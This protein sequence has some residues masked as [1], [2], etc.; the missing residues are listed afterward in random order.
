MYDPNGWSLPG[1]PVDHNAWRYD[2]QKGITAPG[3]PSDE[4]GTQFH[5]G[6]DF[7][8]TNG[9]H[10]L[11]SPAGQ[12][13]PEHLINYTPATKEVHAPGVPAP[14]WEENISLLPNHQG[15]MGGVVGT[16]QAADEDDPDAADI[17][18]DT[19]DYYSPYGT[20]TAPDY[21]AAGPS[22]TTPAGGGGQCPPGTTY[23][24]IT[25]TCVPNG[26]LPP[27]TTGPVR[28]RPVLD[29]NG[30]PIPGLVAGPSGQVIH[31]PNAP[32]DPNNPATWPIRVINGVPHRINPATGDAS[33]VTIGGVPATRTTGGGVRG[34]G[35]GGGAA[36]RPYGTQLHEGRDGSIWVFDP[37]SGD[38]T[39][40]MGPD[41]ARGTRVVG[42]RVIRPTEDG[43]G[44]E[45]VYEVP[46]KPQVV[47]T[48]T[49]V[50]TVNPMTGETRSVW[51]KPE[52]I[53]T[54]AH[55]VIVPYGQQA[56][57][58]DFDG[59]TRTIGTYIPRQS[60]GQQMGGSAP[61]PAE[62]APSVGQQMGGSA[63]GPAEPAP[64]LI[65]QHPAEIPPPDDWPPKEPPLGGPEPYGP[66]REEP[67]GLGEDRFVS[68]DAYYRQVG[69]GQADQMG[70]DEGVEG[71]QSYLNPDGGSGMRYP[72]Y[73]QV[74]V[75]QG[76][77]VAPVPP[78]QIVGG[79]NKFGDQVSMEGTHKGTDLQAYRGTPAV[80]PVNGVVI[81][82]QNDPQGL[83]VQVFVQSADD[84]RIHQLSHLDSVAVGPGTPVQAGQPV[85]TVGD[86]GAGATGPHLDYRIRTPDGGYQNP[87]PEL[88]PL[89]QLPEAPNTVGRG[90]APERDRWYDDPQDTVPYEFTMVR[91]IVQS[92]ESGTVLPEEREKALHPSQ[93]TYV[94]AMEGDPEFAYGGPAPLGG[95]TAPHV[96]SI[97]AL[98]GQFVRPAADRDTELRQ[99][100]QDSW[101]QPAGA[102]IRDTYPVMER[103]ESAPGGYSSPQPNWAADPTGYG[104]TMMWGNEFAR[105][106]V[107]QHNMSLKDRW[108]EDPEGP[109]Y[110]YQH[111]PFKG[112]EPYGQHLRGAYLPYENEEVAQ[113][114]LEEM[115]EVTTH[116]PRG[117]YSAPEYRHPGPSGVPSDVS[118]P[119]DDT[120]RIRPGSIPEG[121]GL[122]GVMDTD[123]VTAQNRAYKPTPNTLM[124]G[125]ELARNHMNQ[126]NMS[127]LPA[128]ESNLL[129]YTPRMRGEEWT[130]N[131]ERLP[132]G[133]HL[134]PEAGWATPVG[135]MELP[136][137]DVERFMPPY[138][139]IVRPTLDLR[140]TM[141]HG[142]FGGQLDPEEMNSTARPMGGAWQTGV[143]LQG[144]TDQSPPPQ[145]VTP[146]GG[147]WGVEF[148]QQLRGAWQ[149]WI[150]AVERTGEGVMQRAAGLAG[151]AGLLPQILFQDPYNLQGTVGTGQDDLLY[152]SG[153]SWVPAEPQYDATQSVDTG[154]SSSGGPKNI[155]IT[156]YDTE[157]L[158][159]YARGLDLQQQQIEAQIEGEQLRHEAAMAAVK[160]QAQAN[161]E[162]ARHNKVMEDLQ[163]EKLQ[164]ERDQM[165]IEL[166]EKG[167]FGQRSQF[168]LLQSAL[169]N[170]W[171]QKL[172]GMAP[173]YYDP[174]GP[175]FVGGGR[176]Q[177][178]LS[179]WV[180]GPARNFGID[181]RTGQ[182][183]SLPD[184]M[185]GNGAAQGGSPR[186]GGG[187]TSGGTTG[188]STAVRP[189]LIRLRTQL[190]QQLAN[191]QGPDERAEIQ[192]SIE[193]LKRRHPE[194]FQDSAPV[195]SGGGGGGGSIG[196]QMASN[197]GW[198]GY[199]PLGSAPP[200][201]SY[202]DWKQMD[203]FSRASWRTMSDMAQPFPQTVEN[204]RQAWAK[205]G[206]YDAPNVSRL[207]MI[208]A[209]PRG[210]IGYHQTAE[211]FGR[212]P[213]EWDEAQQ[214]GWSRALSPSVQ[215][216][217]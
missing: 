59:S 160:N 198:G 70:V 63:P 146:S 212:S 114:K 50:L 122:E 82:V 137:T 143:P 162:I 150:P 173:G 104:E 12:Q 46:E 187:T 200:T 117:G 209:G 1:E 53:T 126:Q 89:G 215:Q 196:A 87:E 86:T 5:L 184:W 35:G 189:D 105:G 33:P 24:P 159:Q 178:L 36:P 147:G 213:A 19:G 191:A 193:G 108:Y 39:M 167:T 88:G 22:T 176:L 217:V 190:E 31:I 90:E 27:D 76:D 93:P 149:T 7:S 75:G 207:S 74:G 136:T 30:K 41:E 139:Y 107:N 110:A 152:D 58:H 201:P 17:D 177:G 4:R 92:A 144:N 192:A 205:E 214:R 34:G 168:E 14:L 29:P 73:A 124:W 211:M 28:G 129:R 48:G 66:L 32:Q 183:I 157:R 71:F 199:A 106:R 188:G 171:L 101:Y 37:N 202:Q 142:I 130:D 174:G 203:P 61:G 26:L 67:V 47:N 84:G 21:P 148:P 44:Y 15:A 195:P 113:R 54:D 81:D 6:S 206:I 161:K 57:L 216:Q 103:D 194:A 3:N 127:M 68:P 158:K 56:I 115:G 145:A 210:Q 16:G 140:D 43:K 80:S 132:A 95:S 170:P 135:N 155:A 175:G 141:P 60:V 100:Y 169:Q 128:D 118:W 49:E 138:D 45:V 181:P 204:T 133:G 2:L 20:S 65:P 121:G 52:Q 98:Q 112:T 62:P 125:N 109:P 102:D 134:G 123:R 94:P 164:N 96:S 64:P 42:N 13:A 78:E 120:R 69:T 166:A 77:E 182:P 38:V 172:T 156:P 51:Q 85:G 97:P 185:G 180:P 131:P 11:V 8:P 163:R 153:D 91:P 40:V 10:L 72:G 79:G 154:S 197:A 119:A 25:G 99:K 179:S 18:D 208:N 186:G 83:G 116:A 111:D 151:A 9:L 23:D 55:H 165:Q